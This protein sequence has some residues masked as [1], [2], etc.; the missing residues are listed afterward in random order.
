M[1]HEQGFT[2]IELLVSLVIIAI[3][4]AA[5]LGILDSGVRVNKVEGGI[6]DAQQSVRFGAYDIVHNIRMARV[7][8]LAYTNSVIPFYNN[9]PKNTTISD[10]NGQKHP[11]RPGTDALEIRGVI[12]S[13]LFSLQPTDLSA[14]P[15]GGSPV[16]ITVEALTAAGY[17]NNQAVNPCFS[18]DSSGT[19]QQNGPDSF[20][21][22][23]TAINNLDSAY[24]VTS[25][26]KASSSYCTPII[27]SDTSGNYDVG[28]LT[29]VALSST[30]PS[31]TQVMTLTVDFSDA[32]GA[33]YDIS[34]GS[35]QQ[36][37]QP[38]GVGLLDDLV[39]F[40]HDGAECSEGGT[41]CPSVNPD[42]G[43][44][45]PFLASA[46]RLISLGG[47]TA[48]YSLQAVADNIEDMQIAY[49]IDAYSGTTLPLS[50][51]GP[52]GSI[53]PLENVNSSGQVQVDGDEWFPNVAGD[54]I[55]IPVGGASAY[56]M[57]DSTFTTTPS[58][59]LPYMQYVLPGNPAPPAQ[60]LLR[61]V[62]I[63]LIAIGTQPDTQEGGYQGPGAFGISVMDSTAVPVSNL[64]YHRRVIDLAATLRNFQ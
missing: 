5:M 32:S 36:L 63:A 21:D 22:F 43:K 29:N 54:T 60:P 45:H 62:K 40:V 8:G 15:N 55:S 17:Y 41:N 3:F 48:S 14:Q 38:L 53:Y 57:T 56:Q 51:A 47:A 27:V 28:T 26:G 23:L 16:A 35:P 46:R 11:V 59:L 25:G 42:P 52:D 20:R 58:A 1:R 12:T 6:S 39:Y 7:G 34:A 4:F 33:S 49:G 30:V 9:T 13:P 31:A 64:S 37:A 18:K 61:A 50:T 24:S 2:L 19:C 44:I 10:I